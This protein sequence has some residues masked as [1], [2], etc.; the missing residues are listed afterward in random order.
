MTATAEADRNPLDELRHA[1]SS[2]ELS[3]AAHQS[4]ARLLSRLNSPVRVVIMGL[5]I[6][7]KSTIFNM[8]AGQVVLPDGVK[9]PTTQLVFGETPRTEYTLSD[10]STRSF[11]G[12]ELDAAASLQPAFVK[13]EMPLQQLKKI[14]LLEVVAGDEAAAQQRAIRWA[15]KRADIAIWC[16]PEFNATELDLWTNV[17]EA[18]QDHSFLVLSKVDILS[19][20]GVLPERIHLLKEPVADYFHSLMPVAAIQALAAMAQDSEQ[21]KLA[22]ASSGGKALITSILRQV[23]DGRRADMDSVEVFLHRHGLNRS[24][25]MSAG[26]TEALTDPAPA[27]AAEQQQPESDPPRVAP[28]PVKEDAIS[29]SDHRAEVD[30]KE[31]TSESVPSLPEQQGPDK[32]AREVNDSS[33]KDAASDA[34]GEVVSNEATLQTAEHDEPQAPQT[35]APSEDLIETEADGDHIVPS[36]EDGAQL[37]QETKVDDPEISTVSKQEPPEDSSSTVDGP[38]PAR[39]EFAAALD[40]VTSGIDQIDDDHDAFEPDG[41]ATEMPDFDALEQFKESSGSAVTGPVV[42]ARA[43]SMT[44][45]SDQADEFEKLLVDRDNMSTDAVIERCI[46]VVDHL[47]DLIL[48]SSGEDTALTGYD[49]RCQ[50]ASEMLVLMQLEADS[51]NALDAVMVVLQLKREFEERDVA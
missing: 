35:A 28:I 27:A 31:T 8:L 49:L 15:S 50:E 42:D 36:S 45:L 47:G 13:L 44:Y 14:N 3:K 51:A 41:E 11:E 43:S 37:E 18:L 5:P 10:A 30:A 24:T 23:R 2:G 48:N 32:D 33:D 21:S 6:S 19:D 26:E 4:G 7:G 12:I 46:Q 25:D 34:P 1:L 20:Q 9:L 22:F 38:A 39:S 17:P 16:T 29:A 40:L